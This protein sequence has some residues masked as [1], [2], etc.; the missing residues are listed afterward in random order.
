MSATTH[1]IKVLIV[2][3]HP[4]FRHGLRQL[5]EQDGGFEVIAEAGDGEAAL[6]HAKVLKPEV[7][8]V[9]V[10]IPKLDGL[11]LVRRL[12]DSK[13][14]PG[15]LVLTMN[16][17]ACTFNAALDAGASGYIVKENAMEVLLQG[18]RAV[19]KGAVY[20]CP[21][22][23][24]HLLRRHQRASALKEQKTGLASL[25]PTE[26]RVL[27]LVSENRTNKQIAA[28]LFISPRTVETHRTNLCRKLELQGAHKLLQFAIENRSAL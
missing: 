15:C 13:P 11:Q 2:D 1:K 18:L 6:A 5:I 20:M 16:A 7:V 3:D 22:M 14:Q 21:A 28:E 25:T 8:V 9:D 24:N 27:L 23:S 19:A 26:R 10:N 12:R 17:D 4:I